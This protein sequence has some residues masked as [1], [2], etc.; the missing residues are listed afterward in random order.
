MGDTHTEINGEE[1]EVSKGRKINIKVVD[2]LLHEV[3]EKH[4]EEWYEDG[5]GGYS[6]TEEYIISTSEVQKL[7][8][9]WYDFD[10]STETIR[11]NGFSKGGALEGY[12]YFTY[13]KIGDPKR[14]GMRMNFV[15]YLR[16]KG[17]LEEM[18]EKYKETEDSGQDIPEEYS[19][20]EGYDN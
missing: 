7:L 9:K 6:Q 10:V 13:N 11:R 4:A 15:E 16:E 18:R 20:V 3:L 17:K 1:V 19:G 12:E 5:L 14:W 2:E 8:Y